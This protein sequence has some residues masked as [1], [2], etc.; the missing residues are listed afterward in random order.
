MEEAEKG[1][2]HYKGSA[3]KTGD[4]KT[5]THLPGI[6][7]FVK[8]QGTYT[9]ESTSR[10]AGFDTDNDGIPDVWEEA[11]GLNPNDAS[12]AKLYTIDTQKKWYTNVE[13]Y[14]NSLV[15]DIMKGGNTDALSAVDEYYPTL[16]TPS[17]ITEVQAETVATEY[18]NLQGIRVEQPRNGTYIRVERMADGTTNSRKVVI[19]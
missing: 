12:D 15:E 5:I 16:A 9:L 10:E 2:T 19:R 1:T 13:I 14:L 7:D 11:N 6:I 18:Y 4:G 17:S 3:T 8:D